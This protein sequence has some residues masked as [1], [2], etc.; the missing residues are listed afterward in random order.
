MGTPFE[1]VYLLKMQRP[2][3]EVEQPDNA[4]VASVTPGA[5]QG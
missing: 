3:L 1:F 2:S 5:S 4:V